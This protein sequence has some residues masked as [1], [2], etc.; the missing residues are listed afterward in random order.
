[1]GGGGQG[2]MNQMRGMASGQAGMG[3]GMMGMGGG[4]PGMGGGMA[5]G[6][7]RGAGP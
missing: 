7:P 2:P 5:Q 6:I 3:G 1:M 4:N